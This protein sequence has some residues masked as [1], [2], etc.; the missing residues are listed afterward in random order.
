[1]SIKLAETAQD[2]EATR[3]FYENISTMPNRGKNTNW[4]V[5]IMREIEKQSPHKPTML[6]K[7]NTLS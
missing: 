7:W 3:Q 2:P 1:M 5:K 4:T 6:S